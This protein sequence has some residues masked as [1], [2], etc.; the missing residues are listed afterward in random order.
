MGDAAEIGA[1]LEQLGLD[2][3]DLQE[4]FNPGEFAK[5][6]PKFNLKP[7]VA[8]DLSTGRDFRLEEQRKRARAE[9]EEGDLAF[10]IMSP[11]CT[12]FSQL[13][14]LLKASGKRDEVKFQRL[15]AECKVF[16]GFCMELAAYQHSRGK[17]FLFEHPWTASS[18]KEECTKSIR[19][20]PGVIGIVAKP[21]GWMTNSREVAKQV[22]IVCDGSHEHVHLLERRAKAAERYPLGLVKAILKGIRNELKIGKGVHAFEVGQT[23]EEPD[24]LDQATEEEMATFYDGISGAVL[25]PIGVK[26]ARMDEVG[27]MSRLGVFERRRISEAL[28]VYADSDFAGCMRTR[29]ST[30]SCTVMVGK[31]WI[32]NS[33]TTQGFNALSTGEAEFHAL[34][35]GGSIGLGL[36]TLAKDM[37]VDLEIVLKCDASAG[38]G[39]AERRGVGR[40][41]HL[42]TPLLWLQRAVQ[43]KKLRVTK[44]AGLENISDIGTKHLDGPLIKKLLAMM[45][46]VASA[47]RGRLALRAALDG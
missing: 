20:L 15:L 24:I 14:E 39:I 28:Q 11:V 4:A 36:K 12:P 26:N 2:S 16:L 22:G 9:I 43:Q 46:F 3:L 27:Y 18:W 13:M 25:D 17:W 30:S 32:R 40:V 29:K 31:H 47:G 5:G 8:M 34:V 44:I 33:S 10:L 7:G 35:N 42:H 23:A 41:R 38:K 21:T 45:G 37:G 6:A 1:L 19:E